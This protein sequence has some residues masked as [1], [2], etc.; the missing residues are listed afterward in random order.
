MDASD[1]D[2]VTVDS[3]TTLVDVGSQAAA[4][5]D[6]VDAIEENEAEAISQSWRSQYIQYS[7]VANDIDEYRPFH[8]LIDLGLQYALESHGHEVAEATRDRIRRV[9][10]EEQL[11]VFDDV[12]PGLQRLTEAGY[13]VYV[14]SNGSPEMLDH[15]LAAAD[16]EDVVEDAVS[17]D[18]VGVYK[19]EAEIY[20]HAAA[21]AG[22][23]IDRILHVSGG[24][25]RDVWGASHA[26][27]RTC[28]LARP[29][30]SPQREHLGNDPDLVAA[31][32]YEVA[33]RLE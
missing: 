5:A 14:V 22:T 24:T 8:E 26:G 15:L 7:V 18:G 25:M 1:I 29:E 23:P 11:A 12:R 33:D 3:Y 17:A 28:W 16:I 30:Q 6:R 20:R 32:L 27:M 10:Y 2:T 21:R 4:I 13:D 31:D 9:V 19:P